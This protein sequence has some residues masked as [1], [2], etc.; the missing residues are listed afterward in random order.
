MA[1]VAASLMTLRPGAYEAFLE[2]HKK[3][4]P[5]LEK[6]GARNVRLMGTIGGPEGGGALAVSFEFDD[7]A[8]YGKFMDNVLADP[9]TMAVL[10]AV[11][12]D[13]GPIASFQQSV[14]SIID[15]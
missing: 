7:Y 12:S 11:G 13:K 5:N 8:S 2:Q 15:E 3:V 10:L 1:V 14:W 4:K 6:A 9:D